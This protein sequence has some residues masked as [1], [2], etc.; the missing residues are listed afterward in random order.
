LPYP[1][2][3]GC[4]VVP[5]SDDQLRAI[6][7]ITVL[8]AQLE[9]AANVLAWMLLRP[10]RG[11]PHILSQDEAQQIG[12]RAFAGDSFASIV[13]RIQRL[14]EYVLR[15]SPKTLAEVQQWT[16]KARDLQERRNE[17]IHAWWS[18][19]SES[20]EVTPVR[21]LGKGEPRVAK[22]QVTELDQFADEIEAAVRGIAPTLQAISFPRY[23][24]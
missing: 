3:E 16:A 23:P 13:T 18:D 9:Y 19:F 22:T 4:K 12:R 10:N 14:S 11:E 20:G 1:D 2:A 21:L 17:L 24:P 15:N 7:R 6:G 5:L 8:S